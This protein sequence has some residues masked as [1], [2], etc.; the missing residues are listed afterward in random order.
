MFGKGITPNSCWIIAPYLQELK[1]IDVATG[2]DVYGPS[3][4][5]FDGITGT[6]GAGPEY[7][8]YN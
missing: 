5:D 2:N 1:D 7:I 3:R 6:V 4:L 8:R